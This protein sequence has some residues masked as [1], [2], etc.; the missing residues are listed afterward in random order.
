MSRQKTSSRSQPNAPDKRGEDPAARPPLVRYVSAAVLSRGADAAA[1][2]GFV[3]LAAQSGAAPSAGALMAAA[4]T[5]PHVLGPLSARALDG[6]RD[7]RTVL[8]CAAVLYGALILAA[9]LSFGRV[10]FAVSLA[11]AAAAGFCGPLLTGGLSSILAPLTPGPE[12]KR[13]RAEG[14]DAL[15]YGIGGTLG[16]AA[17]AGAAAVFG[18]GAALAGL[19]A[20]ALA[21]AVVLRMLPVPPLEPREAARARG[22]AGREAGVMLSLAKIGPLRRTTLLTMAA[23]LPGGAI[24]VLAVAFAERT[25]AGAAGGGFLVTAFGLGN[26]AGSLLLVLRP[27]RGNPENRMRDF[28]AAA[29]VCFALCALAPSYGFLFAALLLAGAV[30]A[31]LMTATLAVR[32]AY[33]PDAIRAQAFAAMAGLKTAAGSAGTAIA[34]ALIGFGPGTLFLA[35]GLTTAAALGAVLLDRSLSGRG[36]SPAA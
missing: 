2:V 15:T 29:A 13:R 26:L 5:A 8:A 24:S 34:G 9:A 36:G 21:S 18:P 4:L 11:L 28:T 16:P 31:P 17:V 1:A 20:S 33:S 35:G 10:P 22:A 6:A 19:S 14:W 23:A 27:L 3:L 25:A 30:N 12:H 32:S 7:R